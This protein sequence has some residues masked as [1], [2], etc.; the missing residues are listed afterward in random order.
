MEAAFH[1]YKKLLSPMLHLHSPGGGGCLYQPTCS[2][3]AAI[4]LAEHGLLRGGG[5]MLRRLLRCHPWGR[6]G[7]DPVPAA[8]K[9]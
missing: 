9:S 4:A 2:E 1:V 5:L 6:G 8:K 7:W 3:Y